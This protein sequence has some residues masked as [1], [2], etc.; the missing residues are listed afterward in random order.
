MTRSHF[1]HPAKI[2]IPDSDIQPQQQT[3]KMS[4]RLALTIKVLHPSAAVYAEHQA[5]YSGD[6][7]LDIF[8]PEDT[9]VPAG[10]RGFILNMG[11]STQ[12]NHTTSGR[13]V[14][15][16]LYPRS[17]MGARTPLRLANSV[18]IIDAGYRGPIC[19]I[20]DN[21]SDTDYL[22]KRG[23]RL[24]QIC[25]ATLEP[26]HV[27]LDDTLSESERGERGIGSTN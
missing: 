7:G 23:D 22:V 27:Y 16:Y 6:A 2:H 17:S 3:T 9:V 11:I 1:V 13:T 12:M 26:F 15:Y 24:V 5:A 21:L 19:A 20:L 4:S 18:G 8:V 10:A 25:S 14:S